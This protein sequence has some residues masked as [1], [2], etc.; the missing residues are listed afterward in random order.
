MLAAAR[1]ARPGKSRRVVGI[2][3]AAAVL[4]AVAIIVPLWMRLDRQRALLSLGEI[5]R[6]ASYGQ[7]EPAFELAMVARR[8]LPGDTTLERLLPLVSDRLTI[9]S[10]PAGATIT[11]QR[12]S[13]DAEGRF[14]SAVSAG[15]TPLADLR[16][17]RGNYRVVVE[18][19][20]FGPVERVASSETLRADGR[21]AADSVIRINVRLLPANEH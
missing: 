15:T 12:I 21:F 16:V 6:L 14:P 20:G 5:E 18:K 11:L 8:R 3:A 17:P 10:D 2:F 13:P 7:F 1:E 19:A 4:L 9:E